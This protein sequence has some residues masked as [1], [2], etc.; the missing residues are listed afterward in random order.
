MVFLYVIFPLHIYP[1]L[2]KYLDRQASEHIAQARHYKLVDDSFL[3]SLI[4]LCL[5]LTCL[6]V[7][8]L[9]KPY[10]GKVFIKT[11][12]RHTLKFELFEKILVF[13]T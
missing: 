6:M 2:G 4:S 11:I 8:F 10:I 12:E 9:K 3:L 7:E 5:Q 13:N 1:L